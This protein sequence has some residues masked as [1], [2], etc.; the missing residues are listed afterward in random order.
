MI[1]K[2]KVFIIAE[3][4]VNHNGSLDI[5]FMLVDKAKEAD[6]DAIKFQTWKTE[7]VITKNAPKPSYQLNQTDA[8]ESQYDMLKKLELSYE[9]FQR[10]KAYCDEKQIMFL[11]TAD[12]IESAEFLNPLQSI[13]KMGSAE[14]TDLPFLKKIARFGKHVIL[15]TGMGNLDEIGMALK[16]L[17]EGGLKKQDITVL[18]C[19]TAYPTPWK[20]VNLR[21]MGNIQ[22]TFQVMVGYSDHTIGTEVTLAAVALGARVVEKHFTLDSKMEGPDHS[23]SIEPK[24]LKR[25]VEMIRHI[26]QSL[27]KSEKKPSP[28]ELANISQVRKSIVAKTKIQQGEIFSED[29]ITVKRPGTGITPASWD[30]IIGQKAKKDFDTDEMIEL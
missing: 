17:E 1:G 8:R 21:A 6:V 18:H 3:A 13:I 11:S 15:S 7:N 26:E 14:L 20:D 30:N 5:A 19:N 16:A 23:S 24:D 22:E 12:E 27:G 29:N 28:S 10:L 2:D 25:M 4:G 9:D